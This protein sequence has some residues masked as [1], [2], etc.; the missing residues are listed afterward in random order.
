MATYPHRTGRGETLQDISKR[1]GISVQ[2]LRE[3]NRIAPGDDAHCRRIIDV[4]L[5]A[6]SDPPSAEEVQRARRARELESEKNH[7]SLNDTR[8]YFKRQQE[9]AVL[10]AAPRFGDSAATARP[11]KKRTIRSASYMKKLSQKLAQAQEQEQKSVGQPASK[12]PRLEASTAAAGPSAVGVPSSN[13]ASQLL[14]QSNTQNSAAGLT[15]LTRPN[16][17]AAGPSSADVLR[18]KERQDE[19]TRVTLRQYAGI[20]MGEFERNMKKLAN[21]LGVLQRQHEEDVE[22]MR[23]GKLGFINAINGMLGVCRMPQV[24]SSVCI[25]F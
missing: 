6:C 16:R 21:N 19:L 13:A 15:T 2:K 4:T 20:L 17:I 7:N 22:L 12:F 14:P 3:E 25:R 10:L 18:E 1:F 5:D 8:A 11:R 9:Q 23:A 24:N